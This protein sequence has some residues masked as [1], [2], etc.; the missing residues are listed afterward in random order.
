[1]IRMF[2]WV[3][4]GTSIQCFGVVAGRESKRCFPDVRGIVWSAVPWAMRVGMLDEDRIFAGWMDAI[5]RPVRDW[6]PDAMERK[7]M[8]PQVLPSWWSHCAA[9]MGEKR[10]KLWRMTMADHGAEGSA[11]EWMATEPPMDMPRMPAGVGL[12]RCAMAASRRIFAG[13]E[14]SRMP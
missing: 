11:M 1:V 3:A 14:A 12:N 5:G 4:S 9:M 10:S 7:I 13:R 8:G 6:N 2:S